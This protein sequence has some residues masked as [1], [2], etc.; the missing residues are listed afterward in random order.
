VTKRTFVVRAL[1]VTVG[2]VSLVVGF[3]EFVTSPF[4]LFGDYVHRVD[5][6]EKVVAMTF[7]DGPHPKHTPVVLDVLD[8]HRIKAT[9]FLMG[10]NVERFGPVARELIRRGHEVGN[11]SYSHPRL[12]FMTPG[13]V[14]EE[15]ERTDEL[16]RSLGVSAPIHFRPPHGARF[17]VLPYVLMKMGKLSVGTDVNPDEWR[18]RPAAVMIESIMRQV[19]PGSIIGL[20]DVLGVETIKTLEHVLDR[21]VADGYRFETVSELLA[22]RR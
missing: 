20:H 6:D 19:K 7:D 10:R 15:V 17:I 11:H 13:R 3:R 18:R 1:V 14:R 2:I 4:Q 9:F 8:R 12:L 16:I 5:T 21:L 22:R